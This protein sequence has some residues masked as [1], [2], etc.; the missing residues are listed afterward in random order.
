MCPKPP[1]NNHGQ[2][3]KFEEINAFNQVT[4]LECVHLPLNNV[5]HAKCLQ[6]KHILVAIRFGMTKSFMEVLR[7]L[8]STNCMEGFY[9]PP[10]TTLRRK[11]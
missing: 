5:M 11:S 4:F 3:L 6:K 1:G 10:P 2:T 8:G 7:T 9:T